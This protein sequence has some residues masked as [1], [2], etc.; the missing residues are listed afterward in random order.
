MKA[1][2]Q[3][4][5]NLEQLEDRWTPSNQGWGRWEFQTLQPPAGPRPVGVLDLGTPVGDTVVACF[6]C[7]SRGIFK[8]W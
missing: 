6:S 7:Q 5:P 2:N 1:K 4:R 8:A 3:F